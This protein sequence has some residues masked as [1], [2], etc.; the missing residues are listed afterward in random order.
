MLNNKTSWNT[1]KYVHNKIIIF[2]THR[3]SQYIQYSQ[4]VVIHSVFTGCRNTISTHRMSQYNQYSQDVAIH[5]VI[6]G[7]LSGVCRAHMFQPLHYALFTIAALT[8]TR[9]SCAKD[10]SSRLCRGSREFVSF[11]VNHH[12]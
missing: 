11:S 4:D 7:L 3:M 5:S 6:V 2:S 10:D 9:V 8:V 12:V 1:H